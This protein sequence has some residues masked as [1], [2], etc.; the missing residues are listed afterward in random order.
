MEKHRWRGGVYR[1]M[2]RPRHTI[3][4]ITFSFHILSSTFFISFLAVGTTVIPSCH[5][6]LLVIPYLQSSPSF[7]YLTDFSTLDLDAS[8]LF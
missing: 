8:L 1:V 2:R 7:L 3:H 5:R 4:I 6:L